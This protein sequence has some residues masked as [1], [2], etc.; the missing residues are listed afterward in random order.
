MSPSESSPAALPA[1]ADD[2]VDFDRTASEVAHRLFG[3]TRQTHKL[4]RFEVTG[5]AGAGAM[6][7]VYVAFDPELDRNVAI[8]VVRD[9]GDPQQA[10][11]R[12]ARLAG[13][14]RALAKVTNSNV[15][16]VYEVGQRDGELF[17]VMEYV[18]G[19]NLRSW[20]TGGEHTES[21]INTLL[22]GAARGLVAAHSAG[23]VHRDFK[24]ENVVVGEGLRAVVLDFGLA[25]TAEAPT[26]DPDDA[27]LVSGDTAA[28][29]QLTR[30]GT[31]AGTPAYMAPEQFEGHPPSDRS[32]QFAFCVCAWE[33]LT[34][35]RPFEL[36]TEAGRFVRRKTAGPSP[37]AKQWLE[38]GLSLDP[39]ARWPSMAALLAT[40]QRAQGRARTRKVMLAVAAVV[41]LGAGGLGYKGYARQQTRAGCV[42]DGGSLVW[43]AAMESQVRQ[44]LVA[45]EEP[46][47]DATADHVIPVL[48]T[49]ARRWQEA[50]TSACVRAEVDATWDAE[51]LD[52]SVWCLDERRMQLESLVV[53][54]QRADANTVKEAMTAASAL[55]PVDPCM[56][57][58]RLM[59]IPRPPEQRQAVMQVRRTL[60]EASALGA[61]GKFS[62]GAALTQEAVDA[63]AA[64]DWPP[65]LAA[66][67]WSRGRLLSKSGDHAEAE[68]ALLAAY[69]EAAEAG[70][71]GVAADA[72]TELVFTVGHS[73]ARPVEGAQWAQHAQVQLAA[74]GEGDG[75][76]RADALNQLGVIRQDQ[77]KFAEAKALSEQTLAMR[78]A[79]LGPDHL[80]VASSLG[81]LSTAHNALGDQTQA[82]ALGR[83]ALAIKEK[84][85]GPEHPNFGRSLHNLSVALAV[86]GEIE[87]ARL[88]S[89]RALAVFEQ[90]H[91]PD[92]PIFAVC[93]IHLA[94]IY[95]RQGAHAKAAVIQ[96]RAVAILSKG[97]GPEHPN[98][99]FALVSLA[100]IRSAAGEHEVAKS[101]LERAVP[102]LE[103]TLGPDHPSVARAIA[104]QSGVHMEL[105]E[106]EAAKDCSV[107][108]LAIFEAALGPDHQ[109]VA[110]AVGNLGR[111]HDA[112]GAPTL[113]EAH[114]TRALTSLEKLHGP[115]HPALKSQLISL[116]RLGLDQSKPEVALGYA[117]RA[118][119]V[120][121]TAE[122]QALSLADARYL[123]ARAL[124]ETPADKGGDRSRAVAVASRAAE[125][126]KGVDAELHAAVQTWRTRHTRP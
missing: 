107:R 17:I 98:L 41:V 77:G 113:A 33:A 108:A 97:P 37:H 96:E 116:A 78:E 74:L 1:L 12:R 104:N 91:G 90:A 42:A 44:G 39:D 69:F 38:R 85:L 47:A 24:P 9:V 25:R 111:A 106:F 28:V 8:K 43:D 11:L 48:R 57:A 22:V 89:E 63:A 23:L 65:L 32:D 114:F 20:L 6:G 75:L 18:P 15:I 123:L 79:V 122:G 55:R 70:A 16:G 3:T 64:L 80:L 88:L 10:E 109:E 26:L 4:G 58:P 71:P 124:W 51:T 36:P 84:A 101:V 61:S 59:R 45:S 52:R 67:Q 34:G 30:T 102:M 60:A 68:A 119:E 2:R 27:S 95:S 93:G 105:G 5:T 54:L 14:A 72:A 31:T 125:G 94:Q 126:S 81:N 110:M 118:A 29:D 100:Q 13:E 62:D 19:P 46:Y 49:H 117:E 121:E 21:E 53:E 7:R 73:L 86:A 92:H 56:D 35:E 83:R 87:A 99:A 50:R 82:I 40:I 76:R 112:L 103:R 66:A 115:D 120:L